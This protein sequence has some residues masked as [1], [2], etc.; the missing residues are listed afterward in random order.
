MVLVRNKQWHQRDLMLNFR[1]RGHKGRG[2]AANCW[3]VGVGWVGKV[4]RG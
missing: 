2:R 1:L 4:G 3:G